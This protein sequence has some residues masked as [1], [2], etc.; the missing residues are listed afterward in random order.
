M[1]RRD[2]LAPEPFNV[3]SWMLLTT[4]LVMVLSI[5]LIRTELEEYYGLQG[6]PW[7]LQA[8]LPAAN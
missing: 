5:C 8:A 7:G 4:V 3:Y 6:F 2:K 1:S